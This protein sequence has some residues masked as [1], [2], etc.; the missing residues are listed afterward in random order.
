[1]RKSLIVLI[2]IFLSC[3][4][5]NASEDFSNR[6]SNV[7]INLPKYR[8]DREEVPEE[9]K[10]RMERLASAIDKASSKYKNIGVKT[11]S[12][13]LMTIA[14]KESRLAKNVGMGRCDLMP[15]GENCD[16]GRAR[17]Y[18]QIWKVA[19]PAVHDENL[20]PGSQEELDIAAG[21]AA[22]LL[23]A[24]LKRCNGKNPYGVWAGGFSGYR[25]YDCDWRPKHEHQ[26]PKA[27]ASYMNTLLYKLNNAH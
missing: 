22:R 27:R 13:A 15:K 17:T 9:R 5:C 20:V 7:L 6:I 8:Q 25:S 14:Y 16:A 23:N 19:C 12:A 26:S 18:F 1:M 11:M 24:A 3:S 4:I 21:C 2:V 10:E